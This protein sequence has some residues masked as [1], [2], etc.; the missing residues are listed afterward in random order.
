M[1][2]LVFFV[3]NIGLCLTRRSLWIVTVLLVLVVLNW[4]FLTIMVKNIQFRIN[5]IKQ[6]FHNNEHVVKFS[7]P[8]QGTCWY[9]LDVLDN[10]ETRAI[11]YVNSLTYT[12]TLKFPHITLL[13]L[14]I[15]LI[16]KVFVNVNNFLIYDKVH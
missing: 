1:V 5:Y 16:I 3:I 7:Y 14:F 9:F 8:H 4:M 15:E 2:S 10:N 13:T 11:L 6:R 12:F